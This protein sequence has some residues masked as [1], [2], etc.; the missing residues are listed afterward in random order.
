MCGV[1]QFK[2]GFGGFS[3]LHMP[4]QDYIYRPFIYHSWRK[5]AQMLR[6]IHRARRKSLGLDPVAQAKN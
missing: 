6:A 4:T 2:R 3:R 5:V 1:Y